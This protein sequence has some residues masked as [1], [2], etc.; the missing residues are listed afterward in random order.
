M[1]QQIIDSIQNTKYVKIIKGGFTMSI[2]VES[3]KR[4]FLNDEITE[5]R[6][7]ESEE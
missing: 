1:M 3:L 4:L 5:K 6:L 2:L 7:E